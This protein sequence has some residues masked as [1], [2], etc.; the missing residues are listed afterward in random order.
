[1]QLIILLVLWILRPMTA[2]WHAQQD[3]F[4]GIGKA[5]WPKVRGNIHSC[6]VSAKQYTWKVTLVYSYSAD[7]DYWSGETSRAFVREKD[8][9]DYATVHHAGSVVMVR[10]CPGQPQKSVVLSEDQMLVSAAG[11]I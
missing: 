9:D 5:D 10:A 3:R 2:T 1:M 6:N 11:A 8:A 7:G 4:R